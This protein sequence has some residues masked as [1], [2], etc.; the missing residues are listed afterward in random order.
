MRGVYVSGNKILKKKLYI[1]SLHLN[2][3]IILFLLLHK[4]NS[5]LN[6]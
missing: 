1:K 5:Y 6:L 2:I 4:N 3:Q